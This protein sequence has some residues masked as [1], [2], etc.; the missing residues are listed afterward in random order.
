[1]STSTKPTEVP[2]TSLPTPPPT[3]VEVFASHAYQ[4]LAKADPW[5]GFT[6]ED[7]ERG[8]R[9]FTGEEGA[10]QFDRAVRAMLGISGDEFIR[11]WEAGAYAAWADKAGYR[12]L[13]HLGLM[14][15]SGRP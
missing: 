7:R 11:R 13:M 14:S 10:F 5:E 12:Y 9:I 2:S 4:R 6:E 3:E 1:M 8:C 15:G